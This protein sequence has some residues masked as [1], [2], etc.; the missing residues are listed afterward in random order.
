MY[1]EVSGLAL[2]PIVFLSDLIMI[3]ARVIRLAAWNCPSSAIT[4]KI[5]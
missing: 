5:P 1:S 4:A 3:L 2:T